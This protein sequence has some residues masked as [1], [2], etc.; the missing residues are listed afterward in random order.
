MKGSIILVIAHRLSTLH[1]LDRL[2]VFSH[3]RIAEQDARRT[4]C[5]STAAATAASLAA[6]RRI[7]V[8]ARNEG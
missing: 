4:C 1:T 8:W 7:S 2:L 3:G 6:K 5:A